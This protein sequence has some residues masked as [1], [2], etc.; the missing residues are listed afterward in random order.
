MTAILIVQGHPDGD[1]GH[2]CHGLAD[3][4][5]EAATEAGH[6]VDVIDLG[7]LEI[8]LLRKPETWEGET[9]LAFVKDSQEKILAA[10]HLVF[11][12]PLWLG[13]VPAVLKAWLE[14]VLRPGFALKINRSGWNPALL[15]GRSARVIVTMGMPAFFYRWFYFAHSLRSLQRN[16]LKFCG[17]G[18]VRT[19]VLGGVGDSSGHVQAKGL[20]LVRD[21]GARGL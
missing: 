18:P 14:Q 21:L 1:G 13:D 8:P 17:I 11:V 6:S 4:Y 15:S 2:L 16:I 5:R 12:Y 9:D 19:T 7:T 20:A 3:T 10:D